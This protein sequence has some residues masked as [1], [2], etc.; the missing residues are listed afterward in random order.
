MPQLSSCPKP[1][2]QSAV[3]RE[4]VNY[5][6]SQMHEAYLASKRNPPTL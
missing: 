3:S 2:L 1:T 6:L 5:V 4:Y